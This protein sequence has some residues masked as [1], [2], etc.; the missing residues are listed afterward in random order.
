MRRITLWGFICY[1]QQ[2]KKYEQG[3]FFKQCGTGNNSSV[4]CETVLGV[5]MELA[6]TMYKIHQNMKMESTLDSK[7]IM[8]TS[9][10]MKHWKNAL[11]SQFCKELKITM[12]ICPWGISFIVSSIDFFC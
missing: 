4:S 10:G 11:H 8:M 12:K 3:F 5:M 1:L 6:K 7:I 9:D 2:V